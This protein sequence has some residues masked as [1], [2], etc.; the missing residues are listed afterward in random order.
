MKS[1]ERA[2]AALSLWIEAQ[3]KWADVGDIDVE[4][5]PLAKYVSDAL[6]AH[7]NEALERAAEVAANHAKRSMDCAPIARDI[8]AAIR[9]LKE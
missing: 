6:R 7:T 5:D 2:R 8:A 1:E 4:T 9:A 3:K